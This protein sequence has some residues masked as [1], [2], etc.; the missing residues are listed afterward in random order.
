[1]QSLAKRKNPLTETLCSALVG[2]HFDLAVFTQFKNH[3]GFFYSTVSVLTISHFSSACCIGPVDLGFPNPCVYRREHVNWPSLCV[4][5]VTHFQWCGVVFF[6]DPQPK[7]P[8][9]YC[10]HIVLQAAFSQIPVSIDTYFTRLILIFV[11]RVPHCA[12]SR[13]PV[14][15]LPLLPALFCW[16]H[17]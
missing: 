9:H 13:D 6:Q 7:P 8:V 17:E 3:C 14:S 2:I 1:M 12:E 4:L 11:S 5:P 15:N 10:W 16:R